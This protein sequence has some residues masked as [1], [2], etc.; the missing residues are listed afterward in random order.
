MLSSHF[1]NV[2]SIKM[3]ITK[4][5]S[6]L[7]L[8]FSLTLVLCLTR[9][10]EFALTMCFKVLWLKTELVVLDRCPER[11]CE[12]KL[13]TF[14]LF[15]IKKRVHFTE[16]VLTYCSL[17][18]CQEALVLERWAMETVGIATQSHLTPPRFQTA[19]FIC[20]SNNSNIQNRMSWK[21]S[22]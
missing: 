20:W 14:I 13:P 5:F 9:S 1:L 21:Q 2:H 16:L 12:G 7:Y 8:C 10:D 19:C 22:I 18:F 11:M 3:I 4:I 17:K 6:Q 15:A